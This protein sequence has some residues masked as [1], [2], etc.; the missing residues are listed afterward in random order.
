MY[1]VYKSIC[2][3]VLMKKC[4]LC[5]KL[6]T[7]FL[8]KN[9]GTM[10]KSKVIVSDEYQTT[11]GCKVFTSNDDSKILMDEICK[12][13]DISMEG[14]N[15]H[16]VQNYGQELHESKT[17]ENGKKNQFEVIS[18]ITL[19]TLI[20]DKK[21]FNTILMLKLCILSDHI[22]DS[23]YLTDMAG[24]QKV[25]HDDE[26]CNAQLQDTVSVEFKVNGQ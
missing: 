2:L 25:S 17:T 19:T 7:I 21:S 18:N 20:F 10:D 11:H 5:I 24:L 23:R 15:L 26:P 4:N 16:D 9:A 22:T 12:V 8:F 14:D 13:M 3:F 6:C 1:I